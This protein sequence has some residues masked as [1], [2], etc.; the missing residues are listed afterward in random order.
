MTT[1][2]KPLKLDPYEEGLLITAIT[3]VLSGDHDFSPDDVERLK[4]LKQKLQE[5]AG[6]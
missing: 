1:P 5:L 4:E 3:R 6:T 2:K